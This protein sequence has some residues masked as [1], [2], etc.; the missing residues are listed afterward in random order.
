MEDI[1]VV[2]YFC[3]QIVLEKQFFIFNIICNKFPQIFLTE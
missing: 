2:V 1:I 3:Y